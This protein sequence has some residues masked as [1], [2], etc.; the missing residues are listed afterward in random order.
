MEAARRRLGVPEEKM[1]TTIQN[2]GNNSAASIPIALS[3]TVKN[4]KISEDDVIVLVGFGGGLT[5]GAL[6]LRWGRY[7]RKTSYK[8]GLRNERKKSSSYRVSGCNTGRK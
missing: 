2:Y 6:A 8:E 3:E 1:A 4:G 5:W 7:N